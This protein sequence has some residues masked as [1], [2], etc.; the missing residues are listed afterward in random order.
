MEKDKILALKHA[1]DKMKY[2]LIMTMILGEKNYF[3]NPIT[4]YKTIKR[5]VKKLNPLKQD[6][7]C[8]F[9]LG[10]PIKK[11]KIY[12][13]L[14]PNV[15][16]YFVEIEI[17]NQDDVDVWMNNFL[18]TSYCNC[19]FVVSNVYYYPTNQSFEQKP[20]IGIDTYWLS[21]IVVNR[22]HGRVLDLCTGSGIQGILAA[23]NSS[24][25]VGVDIDPLSVKIATF[26]TILNEVDEKMQI[27]L[28]SLYE[29]VKDEQF[30]FI[31]SNPPFIPIPSNV[32]FPICG[33]GGEDGLLIIR[34]ILSGYSSHLT[35]KGTGIMIGQAIGNRKSVFL[36]HDI[37]SILCEF[38]N[39]IILSGKLTI[40]N[41][42]FN[43]ADLANKLNCNNQPVSSDMWMDIYKKIG[44]DFLY[45][46]TLF[47]EKTNSY[48]FEEIF[49]DES[50]NPD[51]IPVSRIGSIDNSGSVSY[52]RS[53]DNLGKITLDDETLFFVN[54]I[55]NE[56]SI[57]RIIEGF[58]LRYKIAYGKNF[59]EKL[60]SKYIYLCSMYERHG[61]IE[62]RK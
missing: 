4:D 37:Q 28:G 27:R 15:I 44:A 41:Q 21:R 13:V 5:E 3:V 36:C 32:N 18:I 12:E 40:E 39:Q 25:V 19:Y 53:S 51:D 16:D 23:K 11:S 43:F 60:I 35:D 31:L 50:W 26:N 7:F 52:V 29:P 24:Y 9:A 46:Y 56:K 48:N 8:F 58:P 47:S 14:C 57:R 62:K 6:L 20:Y 45:N 49:I 61:I 34:E 1:L 22:T 54:Q 33:D 10:E 38:S 59:N 2:H 30:D 17:M 55:D 42:A